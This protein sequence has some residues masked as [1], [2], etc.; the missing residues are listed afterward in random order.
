MK[1]IILSL[2]LSMALLSCVDNGTTFPENGD[3]VYYGDLVV[4]DY[5]Q[6]SVGI[7]GT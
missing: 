7:S 6:K 2:F 5:T 4:G 3:G 1:K